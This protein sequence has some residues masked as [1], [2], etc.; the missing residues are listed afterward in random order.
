MSVISD[1]RELYGTLHTTWGKVRVHA[2]SHTIFFVLVFWIGGLTLAN[3]T[4]PNINAINAKDILEND[5][6][7]L[8]KDTG[9]VYVALL[10][11][12][13]FVS[14][15]LTAFDLLGRILSGFFTIL[16]LTAPKSRFS[17]ISAS[18]LAPIAMVMPNDEFELQH[19]LTKSIEIMFKFK[20]QKPQ[21]WNVYQKALSRMTGNSLQYLGDFCTLLLLWIVLFVVHSRIKMNVTHFLPVCLILIA[22][23][24]FASM[25]AS[26]A[27]AVLPILQ[28]KFVWAMI[29]THPS[30]ISPVDIADKDRQRRLLRLEKL[31]TT[32]T[33]EEDQ[34]KFSQPSFRRVF[35]QW[36]R[37]PKAWLRTNV[38]K[39]RNSYYTYMFSDRYQLSFYERGKKLSIQGSPKDLSITD[40]FAYKLYNACKRLKSLYRL[41]V[42]LI[43]YA[44]TGVP[45]M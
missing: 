6:F 22:F 16:F 20:E 3:F 43:R 42:G 14:V 30:L 19:L 2:I 34:D 4:L 41:L 1:V 28:V 15:Y 27:L 21:E 18:E 39:A 17:G 31:L 7:K 5:W 36:A 12:V 26:R 40:V 33:K 8:A 45:P 35:G 24:W 11:P 32:V 25:R 13:L 38:I 29:Q 10:L 9:L 37:T 44:I 23:I